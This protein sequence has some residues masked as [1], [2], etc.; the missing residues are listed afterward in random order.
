MLRSIPHLLLLLAAAAAPKT[1]PAGSR[2]ATDDEGT[3][4]SV[5]VSVVSTSTDKDGYE[6]F[7][8]SAKFGP[9]ATSV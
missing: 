2:F 8:V 1:D 5:K 7:Q 4:P 3:E 9:R 6:T